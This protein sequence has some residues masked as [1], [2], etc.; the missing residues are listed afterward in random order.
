MSDLVHSIIDDIES[1]LSEIQLMYLD[2]SISLAE[3]NDMCDSHTD[4]EKINLKL[5]S[6]NDKELA[7]K[8]ITA[9]LDVYNL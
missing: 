2:G 4:L 6:Q 1:E 9:V 3:L 7:E 5:E 8:L